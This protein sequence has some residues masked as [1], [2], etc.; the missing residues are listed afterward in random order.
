MDSS[1]AFVSTSALNLM[2]NRFVS[3]KPNNLCYRERLPTNIYKSFQAKRSEQDENSLPWRLGELLSPRKQFDR[4]QPK[5]RVPSDDAI[6]ICGTGRVYKRCC[7]PFHVG[8]S[9]P[10]TA[11]ELL[12]A[13]FSAFAYRLSKYIMGTT[14]ISNEDW[15]SDRL[16]WENSILEF[17]DQYTFVSLDILENKVAGPDITYILFRANLVEKGEPVNFIE[18]SKFLKDRNR[19]YYASGRLVDIERGF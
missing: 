15:T 17:C 6:C 2:Y 9:E 8:E 19:W 7:R 12:R 4:I 11:L 16:S 3:C 18:R 5:S 13:R 1:Q 14:H 10:R